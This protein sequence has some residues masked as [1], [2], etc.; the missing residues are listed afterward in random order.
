MK[1]LELKRKLKENEGV[2]SECIEKREKFNE[3]EEKA[4]KLCQ[5]YG[6]KDFHVL[7]GTINY[8]YEESIKQQDELK[9][10][11][12]ELEEYYKGLSEGYPIPM[13]DEVEK[14]YNYIIRYHGNIVELGSE[15]VKALSLEK[16]KEVL[17]KNPLLPYAVIVKSDYH[18]IMS[19]MKLKE[20]NATSHIVKGATELW[21]N[22]TLWVA[23]LR[24][25]D[26][27]WDSAKL[28]YLNN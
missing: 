17:E 1:E 6:E 27:H 7:K 8:R 2:L 22:I 16:R 13:S 21:I 5:V 20:L 14:I 19:D 26:S 9:G 11:Q 18:T 10:K 12:K 25:A 15:F 4:K 28:T 3:I 23:E 24:T